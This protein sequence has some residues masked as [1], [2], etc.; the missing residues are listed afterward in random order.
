[1]EPKQYICSRVL[2]DRDHI[3]L[4]ILREKGVTCTYIPQQAAKY[5]EL[6]ANHVD[7]TGWRAEIDEIFWIN[8]S[9]APEL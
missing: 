1:M 8:Q 2:I 3:H 6:A 4:K 7:P 9:S 5:N